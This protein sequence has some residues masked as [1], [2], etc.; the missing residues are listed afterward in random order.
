MY[1]V[2][3]GKVTN[4]N[5]PAR[6][7]RI[8]CI[9][10]EMEG[11]EYPEWINPVFQ[12]VLVFLPNV[13]DEVFII[14]PDDDDIIEFAEDIYYLGTSRTQEHPVHDILTENNEYPKRVGL[15]TKS[16]HFILI[17]DTAGKEEITISHKGITLISIT[18][19]GIFYGTKSANEPFVL[20]LEWKTL[21][22]NFMSLFEAHVH[23]TGTG[24]SGPP[25]NTASVASLRGDVTKEYHLSDFI[26]GQKE[27]PVG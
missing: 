17:N 10:S 1:K 21:M 27:K 14:K 16:G 11:Q 20:G 8:K 7:G 9:L 19:D 3:K 12:G 23:P 25:D 18:N 5:D 6:A 4:I 22:E 24:P 15:K 13:E 2:T 26:F